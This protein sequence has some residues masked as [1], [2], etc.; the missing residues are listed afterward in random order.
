MNLR[1]SGYLGKR[2]G[3]TMGKGW[4]FDRASTGGIT[5]QLVF[6]RDNGLLGA[7]PILR[8]RNSSEEVKSI[9][10]FTGQSLGVPA[11]ATILMKLSAT[12][13]EAPTPN[14]LDAEDAAARSTDTS[15]GLLK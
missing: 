15:K 11:S 5:T 4:A 6:S 3:V 8:G 10:S 7:H 12:A 9:R 1:D 14:D 2:F 13:R